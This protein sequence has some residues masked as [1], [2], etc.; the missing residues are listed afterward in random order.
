[1]SFLAYVFGIIYYLTAAAVI[2]VYTLGLAILLGAKTTPLP[3]SLRRANPSVSLVIPTYNEASIIRRKLDNVLQIDYPREKFE[4]I[5]VD[6]ASTDQTRSIVNRF[7]EENGHK[8]NLVLIEQ[9]VR[10]GK[11]EAINEAMRKVRSEILILT[12]ADVTFSPD[13]VSRLV[14][15]ID[16][17]EVGAVSGV[18]IPV[19]SRS[20]LSNLES[21]YR[22]VY[23]AIRLAEASIDTPF[24]C[25]SELSAYKTELLEPLRPG[26]VCDDVE[27]TLTVRRKGFRAVYASNVPFFETEADKLGPKLKHK[28]RR[29]MNNQHALLQNSSVLFSGNLGKYGKVVFPFEFFVHVISPILLT[30]ALFSFLS[31]AVTTPISAAIALL[32]TIVLSFPLLVITHFLVSR[33]R[34][35][36]IQGSQGIGS[37]V[38]GAIAFSAFQLLLMASL[39]KLAFGGP[40]VNWQQISGTRIPVSVEATV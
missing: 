35:I 34:G 9:P 36:D 12:D 4:V 20:F 11:S 27:L 5:V 39:F 26:T 22:R 24:M 21:G 2:V 14:E 15:N 33:Y 3:R 10:R 7:A 16:G 25:E 28:F 23:T 13:S 29:G 37:W 40:Q 19:G 18:E 8:V 17:S 32:T 38:L 6:S 1:M 30:I 31:F